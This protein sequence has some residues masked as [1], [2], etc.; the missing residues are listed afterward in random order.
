LAFE[1]GEQASGSHFR[2]GDASTSNHAS[3]FSLSPGGPCCCS[4][5]VRR[6]RL[7]E[8]RG[9]E[10]ECGAHGVERCHRVRPL[11]CSVDTSLRSDSIELEHLRTSPLP[12]QETR[13]QVGRFG[14]LERE[15]ECRRSPLPS[16]SLLK[17][18]APPSPNPRTKQAKGS[19]L[20][21]VPRSSS[22][23]AFTDLILGA[24][25]LILWS[26]QV[27]FALSTIT[28]RSH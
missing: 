15:V 21:L 14:N 5:A 28:R 2:T 23:H 3:R 27:Q 4:R 7:K 18:P 19:P 16:V 20:L 11:L 12:A 25:K 17:Q 22:D 8:P 1:R 26:C 10:R 13:I 6:R 24:T 9:G